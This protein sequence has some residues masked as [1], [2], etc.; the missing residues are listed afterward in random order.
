MVNRKRDEHLNDRVLLDVVDDQ[1]EHDHRLH[2]RPLSRFYQTPKRHL[3]KYQNYGHHSN[4]HMSRVI[5]Q[6]HFIYQKKLNLKF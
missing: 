5:D 4:E 3:A 1:S 2:N 6:N